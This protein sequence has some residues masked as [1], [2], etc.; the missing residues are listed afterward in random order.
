MNRSPAGQSAIDKSF[1]RIG[2][3]KSFTSFSRFS[4]EQL[5]CVDLINA[6]MDDIFACKARDLHLKTLVVC[7]TGFSDHDEDEP[8]TEGSFSQF[9]FYETYVH[10]LVYFPDRFDFLLY[11]IINHVCQ[12]QRPDKFKS[13]VEQLLHREQDRQV[14]REVL[15]YDLLL[16]ED[17]DKRIESFTM[18][19]DW[20][21]QVPPVDVLTT[22]LAQAPDR[23]IV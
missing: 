21:C 6:R 3:V 14:P 18:R 8:M 23:D 15:D 4:K 20:V 10:D 5:E 13:M 16:K 2:G 11:C 22:Q 9:R 17:D 7:I 1:A 19:K 12:V